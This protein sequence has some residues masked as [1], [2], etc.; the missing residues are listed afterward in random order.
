M[1]TCLLSLVMVCAGMIACTRSH[2]ER[3]EMRT[4][5]DEQVIA[6]AVR[7]VEKTKGWSKNDYRIE[8]NR[9]ERDLI[10]VW[11]IHTKDELTPIPGGGLSFEVHVDS[12]Q[13]QVVREL[14][15]Q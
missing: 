3:S 2:E 15:F 4:Q 5:S 7:Y 1:W 11:V 12:N 9:R 6:T 10:V 8:I 13:M 14:G